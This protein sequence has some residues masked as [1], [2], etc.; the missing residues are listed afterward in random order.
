MI[1]RQ[2]AAWHGVAW[3]GKARRGEAGEV[4]NG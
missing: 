4:L 1:S 3:R 2:R